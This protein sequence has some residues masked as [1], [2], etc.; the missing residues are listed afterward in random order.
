VPQELSGLGY[1]SRLVH[2]VFEAL[3][4]DEKGMIVKCPFMSSYAAQKTHGVLL[5]P[6]ADG[7]PARTTFL[8]DDTS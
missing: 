7:T 4:R 6:Q 8:G 5:E 2:G 1:G 3:R